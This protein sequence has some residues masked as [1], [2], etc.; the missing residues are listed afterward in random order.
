MFKSARISIAL[1]AAGLIPALGAAVDAAPQKKNIHVEGGVQRSQFGAGA[2]ADEV[3]R[4]AI[5][6]RFGGKYVYATLG[7]ESPTDNVIIE[8]LKGGPAHIAGFKKGDRILK[9]DG[10]PVDRCS[11]K[12]VMVK[13]RGEPGT[14]VIITI[15]R[16][17]QTMDMPVVRG[18]LEKLPDPLFKATLLKQYEDVD[19]DDRIKLAARALTEAGGARAY[20]QSDI[21]EKDRV[22]AIQE[23]YKAKFH[24]EAL[25]YAEAEKGLRRAAEADPENIEARYL[26]ALILDRLNK[27]GDA[28]PHL[29]AVVE[30]NPDWLNAWIALGICQRTRGDLPGA[31]K[32][33]KKAVALTDNKGQETE[34]RK[35]IAQA[36]ERISKASKP[37]LNPASTGGGAPASSDSS[38]PSPDGLSPELQKTIQAD[39]TQNEAAL[40]I[41]DKRYG[42]AATLLKEVLALDPTRAAAWRALAA[43]YQHEKKYSASLEAWQKFIALS[44][45]KSELAPAW[46]GVGIC[47]QENHKFAEAQEAFSKYVELST[48]DSQKAYAWHAIANLQLKEG[49]FESA[50]ESYKMAISCQPDG[51]NAGVLKF[52][53]QSLKNELA[54]APKRGSPDAEDYLADTTQSRFVRWSRRPAI[55]VYIKDGYKTSGYSPSFD[56]KLRAAFKEWENSSGGI[57]KFAFVDKPRSAHIECVWT[58][59]IF[60]LGSPIKGGQTS[61]QIVGHDIE[62]ATIQMLTINGLTNTPI[63]EDGAYLVALHEIGHALGLTGHSPNSNDVMFPYSGVLTLSERDKKTLAALYKTKPPKLPPDAYPQAGVQLIH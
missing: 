59:N 5:G 40:M 4:G 31:I 52:Q 63:T 8:V 50:L 20:A 46:L 42:K 2:E 34:L 16:D 18:G 32:S 35:W 60:D 37:A 22:K 51:E 44:T 27:P 62:H 25:Q 41:Q 48:D 1:V 21:P 43:C 10:E 38:A 28:I 47:Q 57:V 56:T 33:F 14:T 17:G 13:I 12:Q 36:Q 7:D 58:D 6:I 30:K 19:R 15:S 54:E 24:V 9:V 3:D 53:L 61:T 45:D 26:Y 49:K 23:A 11:T 39:S 29:A 55:K